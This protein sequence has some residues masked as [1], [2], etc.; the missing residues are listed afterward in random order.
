MAST[1]LRWLFLLAAAYCASA[2]ACTT[3]R[4]DVHGIAGLDPRRYAGVWWQ[5]AA[6]GT[7]AHAMSWY[8]AGCRAAP[9][10][11]ERRL[12]CIAHRIAFVAQ[13]PW[14]SAKL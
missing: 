8:V 12:D 1:A 11:V 4:G 7:G 3:A 13:T 5:Q 10:R 14:R 2:S 6:W 9:R